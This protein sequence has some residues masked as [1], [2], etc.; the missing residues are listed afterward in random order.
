MK[1]RRNRK[2]RMTGDLFVGDCL[3]SANPSTHLILDVH[4]G[5]S[6]PSIECEVLWFCFDITTESYGE[7]WVASASMCYNK[8]PEGKKQLSAV[9]A[10][11]CLASKMDLNWRRLW[12]CRKKVGENSFFG[13]NGISIYFIMEYRFVCVF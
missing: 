6:T 2:V 1:L 8:W 3:R 11:L 12:C 10:A 7:K 4:R 13:V 9:R 5:S